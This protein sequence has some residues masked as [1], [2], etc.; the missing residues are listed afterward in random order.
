MAEIVVKNQRSSL[1]SEI[2]DN[3]FEKSLTMGS[4]GLDNTS[5]QLMVEKLKEK[6]Y[7]EWAQSIKLITDG[8]GKLWYLTGETR[9]PLFTNASLQKW[10]SENSLVI[11]RLVNSMKSSIEKTYMFLLTAKEVWDAI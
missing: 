11:V 4:N 8:K 2:S 3:Q 1:S 9:K 7:L 5:F 6:N 10:K